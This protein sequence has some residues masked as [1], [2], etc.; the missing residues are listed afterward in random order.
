MQ[1]RAARVP[2][3]ERVRALAPVQALAQVP[4]QAELQRVLAQ[5]QQAQQARRVLPRLRVL[6]PPSFRP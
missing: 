3:P 6:Q 5:A 4:E 2:A 1:V